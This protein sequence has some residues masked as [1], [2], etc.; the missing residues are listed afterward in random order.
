MRKDPGFY[1]SR[2]TQIWVVFNVC[3]SGRA[4]ECKIIAL[5]RMVE[6]FLNNSTLYLTHKLMYIIHE[7]RSLLTAHRLKL[8]TTRI[9]AWVN[10]ISV[11]NLG[12]KK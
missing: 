7:V 5:V 3:P 9:L 6:F 12:T 1:W 10:N 4:V 11:Y 2:A 8:V